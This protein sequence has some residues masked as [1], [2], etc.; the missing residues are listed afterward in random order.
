MGVEGV[1]GEEGGEGGEGLGTGMGLVGGGGD[2][3]S[4]D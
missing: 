1:L 4:I 3:D 2:V